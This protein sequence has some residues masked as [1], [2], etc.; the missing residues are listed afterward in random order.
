MRPVP[1]VINHQMTDKQAT[2]RC[3]IAVSLGLADQG[4]PLHAVSQRLEDNVGSW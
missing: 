3:L 1:V 4:R 2:S